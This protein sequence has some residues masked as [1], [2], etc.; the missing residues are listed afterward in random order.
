MEWSTIVLNVVEGWQPWLALLHR[1][2]HGEQL[3]GLCAHIDTTTLASSGSKTTVGAHAS[4][5]K[6]SEPAMY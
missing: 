1:L 4:T 6:L 3:A 5:A 2:I